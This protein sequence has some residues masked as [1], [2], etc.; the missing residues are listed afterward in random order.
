MLDFFGLACRGRAGLF[1]LAMGLEIKSA[2]ARLELP[3][4]TKLTPSGENSLKEERNILLLR[5]ETASFLNP[6]PTEFSSQGPNECPSFH[7]LGLGR[8]VTSK[9][10]LIL[11]TQICF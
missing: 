7:T 1:T 4:S 3:F 5:E 11:E 2:V 9:A 8:A 6:I 10:V